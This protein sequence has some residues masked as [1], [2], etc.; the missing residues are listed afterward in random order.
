VQALLAEADCVLAIGTELS[1]EEW[2]LAGDARLG[3]QDD[4]L[5]R[6]DI[7]PDR[8]YQTAT[9]ALAIAAD[10]AL[11]VE[12]VLANLPERAAEAPDLATLRTRS[13]AA[14]NHRLQRHRA[15]ID[16]LWEHLPEAV[17][18]GDACEPAAAGLE[19]A[20]PPAP[21][22]WMTA[23]AGF[24]APGWALPAAIGAKLADPRRPMVALMG[25]VDVLSVLGE[26]ATAVE[27]N[28]HVVLLVWNT[29][30]LGEVREQMKAGH[31]RPQGVDMSGV[32]LQ[33]LARGLGA[34]YARVHGPDYFREAI[35]TAIMRP[36]PTVLELREDYW[37]G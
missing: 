12:A 8:L 15:L 19:C 27:T 11:L 17:V 9:P 20:A 16:S 30:G 13:V 1:P 23:G 4:V 24:G 6:V 28:A 21:R 22:R 34:A 7:D 3:V 2:G 14:M 29:T 26:L 5:I 25:D 36:G 37:F 18:F 31:I 10:A 32:D 33:P 35:R